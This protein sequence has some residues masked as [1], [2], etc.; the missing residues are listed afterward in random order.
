M[1]DTVWR[2]RSRVALSLRTCVIVLVPSAIARISYARER[3]NPL[4]YF[5]MAAFKPPLS[6]CSLTRS[7]SSTNILPADMNISCALSWYLQPFSMRATIPLPSVSR[8]TR[9]AVMTRAPR[10]TG[11]ARDAARTSA[12]APR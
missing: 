4:Q 3:D 9:A 11:I 8:G 5:S 12:K 2:L 7:R 1:V 6:F 10:Q